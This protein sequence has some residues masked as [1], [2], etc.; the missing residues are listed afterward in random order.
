MIEFKDL[1]ALAV[2]R[3]GGLK[4]VEAQLPAVKTA[5]QL[6]PRTTPF[7]FPRSPGGYSEPGSSIPWWTPNGRRLKRRFSVSTRTSWC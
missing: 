1:L 2:N 4:P 6:R 7:I 5:A 3:K